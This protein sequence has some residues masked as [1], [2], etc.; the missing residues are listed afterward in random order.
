M[1]GWAGKFHYQKSDKLENLTWNTRLWWC[2]RRQTLKQHLKNIDEFEDWR[3]GTLCSNRT[4][5]VD[6]FLTTLSEIRLTHYDT[7]WNCKTELDTVP[8]C[9]LE[10]D[11]VQSCIDVCCLVLSFND[12]RKRKGNRLLR[13]T[14][15]FWIGDSVDLTFKILVARH[16]ND[17]SIH[18]WNI[19]CEGYSVT[20]NKHIQSL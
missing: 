17:T 14:L 15:T 6:N 10:L 13:F 16:F 20:T 11:S 4:Q 2:M 8:S 7:S 19:W 1:L 9:T 3:W 12:L 5:I 18:N